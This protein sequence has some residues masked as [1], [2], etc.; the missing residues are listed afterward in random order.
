MKKM[1]KR[2]F[3]AILSA[4][5][6]ILALPLTG[7]AASKTYVDY[8][9][10][11]EFGSYPQTQVKDAELI[12][13]LDNIGKSWR[14]YGYYSG[15]GEYGSMVQGDW[16]KYADFKYDGNKYRAVTFSQ[17]RPASTIKESSEKNSYQDNNGYYINNIYYFLYEPIKWRVVCN[18]DYGS[19]ACISELI[20]DSQAFQNDIYCLKYVDQLNEYETFKIY[21]YFSQKY[22]DLDVADKTKYANEY[23]NSSIRE[24]MRTEFVNTAITTGQ[25]KLTSIDLM[26]VEYVYSPYEPNE[27]PLAPFLDSNERKVVGTDYAKAQGLKVGNSDPYRNYNNPT[28]PNSCW[29]L[30]NKSGDY[31]DDYAS[32]IGESCG[33]VEYTGDSESMTLYIGSWGINVHATYGGI[34]PI[35]S[36]NDLEITPKGVVSVEKTKPA[37]YGDATVNL[38]V[39][40]KGNAKK[41]RFHRV[42]KYNYSI[43]ESLTYDKNNSY[44]K[45]IT[46]NPDG[47]ETWNIDFKIREPSAKYRVSVK[48]DKSIYSDSGWFPSIVFELTIP[49]KEI[50]KDVYSFSIDECY[51]DVMYAGVHKVT[52]ETGVDATKVQFYKDGNTW[53]YSADNASFVIEDDKKIWSINMNFSELGEDMEYY[54]RTRS[55]KS[56]FE[57]TDQVMNVWVRFK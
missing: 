28:S 5:M 27:D 46:Q 25:S 52:V 12:K 39:I 47:T 7:F 32:S 31:N 57:F 24:W 49:E 17:Y 30:K 4:I 10:I 40:V 56:A 45:S 34:R 54:I 37:F 16:M 38:D 33:L 6:L 50:D 11:I 51:D 21:R 1:T 22:D 35:I 2:I 42:N 44:V 15:N 3:S 9:D 8:G 18:G 26:S 20:L 48:Y 23:E 41:L 53:T 14:S 29:I 55:Q 13:K 43:G 19:V 36:R